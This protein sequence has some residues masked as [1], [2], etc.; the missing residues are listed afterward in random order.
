MRSPASG[1]CAEG[2]RITALPAISAGT[3]AFTA[4]SSG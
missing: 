4:V 2:L 3:T 1:V